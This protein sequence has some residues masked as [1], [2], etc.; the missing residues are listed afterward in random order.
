M[1]LTAAAPR[2][3]GLKGR[4]RRPTD[5][6][7]QSTISNQVDKVEGQRSKSHRASP[8]GQEFPGRK[9]MIHD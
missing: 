4:E 2:T 8:D 3:H 1:G 5:L 7:L 9:A 6:Y